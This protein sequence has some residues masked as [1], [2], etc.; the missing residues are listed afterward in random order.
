M[1][2]HVDAEDNL[3]LYT[4]NQ[5]KEV[6]VRVQGV[7]ESG[8]IQ[9][10]TMAEL[11]YADIEEC[12]LCEEHTLGFDSGGSNTISPGDVIVGE[13]S[14]AQGLVFSVSLTSGTW[15]GGDAA[16][17]FSLRRVAGTFQNDE[18]LTASG[19]TGA[20]TVNGSMSG[21]GPIDLVTGGLAECIALISGSILPPEE[22][23]VVVGVQL[24]FLIRYRQI[25]GNPY[26]QT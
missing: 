25:A 11:L 20:A 6:P 26:S 24:D 18:E 12:I 22:N 21:Q 15:A 8:S 9:A 1:G 14:S 17:T 10:P 3:D 13:T 23:G 5:K 7:A 16:G 19:D 4:R 2:F